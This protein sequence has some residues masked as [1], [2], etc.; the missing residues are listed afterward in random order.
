MD[1]LLWA[2]PAALALL[3]AYR[4]ADQPRRQTLRL[5]AAAALWASLICLIITWS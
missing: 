1:A 4:V 2:I 5:V 3:G